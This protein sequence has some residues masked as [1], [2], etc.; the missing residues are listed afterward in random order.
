MGRGGMSHRDA[1]PGGD[2]HRCHGP[3]GT[4]TGVLRTAEVPPGPRGPVGGLH[5]GPWTGGKPHRGLRGSPTGLRTRWDVP[6]G[7]RTRW[8]IPPVPTGAHLPVGVSHGA[9]Q[10]TAYEELRKI[11]VRIKSPN[12]EK[13]QLDGDKVL[14]IRSRLQ[15][16]PNIDGNPRYSDSWHVVKETFRAL[17][18]DL[19]APN[20]IKLFIAH[21]HEGI[22]GFYRGI[23]SSILRNAPAASL[24]FVVY[25]NVL[26]LFSLARR[27]H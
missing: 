20:H 9:I 13:N 18:K 22:R 14:V 23:T 3:V 1:M 26:R 16:R 12:G 10:F 21:R 4:P 6:P 27:Q 19:F 7:L 2:S 8:D 15:Q 17:F 11:F 5:R 24:T 25:E